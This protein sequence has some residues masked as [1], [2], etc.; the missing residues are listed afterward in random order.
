MIQWCCMYKSLVSIFLAF[1]ISFLPFHAHATTGLEGKVTSLMK[2]QKA[3]YAGILLDQISAS[4]MLVDK[5]YLKIELELSLRKEMATKMA[6]KDLAFDLLK[7]EHDSLKKY[8]L[9][10]LKLKEKQI[11]DLNMMMKDSS[12]SNAHWWVL[13]G[14]V[15]GIAMSVLV[16]YASVEVVKN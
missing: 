3:P 1:C 5:K 13:G 16:F 10:V 4:K 7:A 15:V 11:G 8:H 14:V 9:E 12:G 2:G 6:S